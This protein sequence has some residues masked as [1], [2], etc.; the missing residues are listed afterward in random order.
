MKKYLSII[1]PVLAAGILAFFTLYPFVKPAT[2]GAGAW[3]S[4]GSLIVVSLTIAMLANLTSFLGLY[5]KDKSLRAASHLYETINQRLRPLLIGAL[6]DNLSRWTVDLGSTH[7]ACQLKFFVQVLIDD[8]WRI[9]SSTVPRS[10]PVRTLSLKPGEG[11]NGFASK[12]KAPVIARLDGSEETMLDHSGNEIGE[13][14][15]LTK[16]SRLKIDPNLAW[17]YATPIFRSS[18]SEPYDDEVLGTLCVD[19]NSHGAETLF[20]D[21]AFQSQVESVALNIGPYLAVLRELNGERQ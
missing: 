5:E 18:N 3:V 14:P 21:P 2:Q 1:P 7:Q 12:H 17:I 16:S 13:Q 19:S 15:P 6:E 4:I 10:A 9:L 8:H 11:M 20:V